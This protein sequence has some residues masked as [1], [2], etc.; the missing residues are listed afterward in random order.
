MDYSF[1]EVQESLKKYLSSL[2]FTSEEEKHKEIKKFILHLKAVCE[3]LLEG[4][5]SNPIQ[6]SLPIKRELDNIIINK[7]KESFSDKIPSFISLNWLIE[8][9]I[10]DIYLEMNSKDDLYSFR[11][12][13]LQN[14]SFKGVVN[15]PLKL[16]VP[17]N[18]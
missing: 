2:S 12:W 16:G 10:K 7:L 14:S 17:E 18:V 4:L 8:N 11:E 3:I 5:D 6:T 13:I 1:Q 15:D 9:G